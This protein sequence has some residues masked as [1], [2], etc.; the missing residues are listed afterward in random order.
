MGPCGARV[1]KIQ[2]VQR[3]KVDGAVGP[4]GYGRLSAAA[5]PT[6]VKTKQPGLRPDGN[7][8]LLV[9]R[10]TSPGGGSLLYAYP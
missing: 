9:L 2:R 3:R 5:L 8:P 1:Q 4:A 10:T 7:A 6:A